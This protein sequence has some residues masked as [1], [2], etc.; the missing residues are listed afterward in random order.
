MLSDTLEVTL[1]T[2]RS[3]FVFLFRER[4][5]AREIESFAKDVEH[6][7]IIE[8]METP[9]DESCEVQLGQAIVRRPQ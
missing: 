4:D 7:S 8:N 6:N 9:I 1:D 2:T 3:I 5:E